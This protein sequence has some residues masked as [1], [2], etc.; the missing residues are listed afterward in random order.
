MAVS[1]LAVIDQLVKE[2]R[3]AILSRSNAALT[4][5]IFRGYDHMVFPEEIAGLRERISGW[6][7]DA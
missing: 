3:A 2:A 4:K 7:K 6:K 1:G 5:Q